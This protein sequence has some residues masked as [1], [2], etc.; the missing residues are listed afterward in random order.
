M[1]AG[2]IP[3]ANPLPADDGKV[4]GLGAGDVALPC[5]MLAQRG[6]DEPAQRAVR[7]GSLFLNSASTCESMVSVVRMMHS[8]VQEYRVHASYHQYITG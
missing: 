2:S 5:Q 7:L 1:L 4:E 6:L 3:G 8:M